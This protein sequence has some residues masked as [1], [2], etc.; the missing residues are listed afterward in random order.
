VSAPTTPPILAP[1]HELLG[2]V[3][4]GGWTVVERIEK[5][6]DATG[7]NF[8]VGY[9]VEGRDGRPGFLKA[10]D[11]SSALQRPDIAVVLQRM[12]ES[13]IF[14][15][16]VLGECERSGMSRIVRVLGAGTL[17]DPAFAHAVDYL[18]LEPADGDVR[19]ALDAMRDFDT[20]WALTVCHHAAVGVQQM[21][22]AGLAHQDVKPSN[23]LTFGEWL[24]KLGDVGRASKRGAAAPH[25]G[26]TVRGDPDYAP[27]ELLYGQVDPDWAVRCQACDL[28]LL[29]SLILFIFTRTQTTGEIVRRLPVDYRPGPFCEPYRVALPYVINA[30]DEVADDFAAQLEGQ[31]AGELVEHFRL[32]C[33][34]DPGQR[35]DPIQRR[36]GQN[37]YDLRRVIS[38]LDVLRREARA[39]Y[40]SKGSR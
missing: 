10:L 22:A 19:R 21:H 20:T 14:E 6:P 31:R 5:A 15:R 4:D 34:P 12:T 39:G 37:P 8:S 29:G 17:V 38:R 28:Y 40:L 11:Y 32:L 9:R 24:A 16:G 3:L 2:R 36:R 13:Y 26:E 30:F 33:H 27:P 7:G 35:G 25:D 1:A 18:I 23:F